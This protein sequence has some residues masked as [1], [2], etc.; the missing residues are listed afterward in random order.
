MAEP[1]RTVSPLPGNVSRWLR[2]ALGGLGRL[3]KRIAAVSGWRRFAVA[4]G[5][6]ALATAALPPVHLLVLLVPA[7]VGLV[8]LIDAS[9]RPRTAFAAGWWFGFGHFTAG[10]YW[11]AFALLTK[12]ERFGW[13]VPFAVFGLSALMALFP[14]CAALLTRAVRGDGPGR[15]LIF[16]A[17][18]TALEWVRGWAFTGFPWN[19]IGTAW[20][21]SDGMIQLAA[22]TGVYGLSLLSV[23]VAAMPAVL[24]DGG[25][26]AGRKAVPVAAA[27]IV[28][29]VVWGGGLVRLAGASDAVV[30]DVRLRL[31]QPNIDQKLK[32][33]PELRQQHVLRQVRMSTAAAGATQGD[34]APTHVIWAETAAPLVLGSDPASLGVIGGAAP[35]GGL[36]ITGTIRRTPPREKPFRI[37]N[38][39]QAVD[40]RAR[41][42]A[43]YDKF[44]LV[45]FG[46]YVPFRGLLNI[47]KVTEGQV[48]FARGPGVRTLRL[49]GLPPVSPLIC[50]EV[51]FPGRVADRQDRPSWLLNITNDAWYGRSSGPYQHF[52]AAR[53]RAVEEGLPLVRVAGTGISAVVDAYGRTVARLGLGRAG[54]IDSALPAPLAGATPYGR[55][56]DRIVLLILIA[57]AGAGYVLQRA[58]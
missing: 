20:V 25:A 35:P 53:M 51:I 26:W 11:I 17:A 3:Q 9:P 16:G 5:L 21:F 27:F 28:L 22:V 4:A 7:F 6:G 50:Y 39:L 32:W 29:G 10:L 23:V 30:P 45:P 13:M 47:A 44:H 48:D 24:T 54:V 36:I 12:P 31:V 49:P 38:S 57:V 37:W 19:L 1:G 2:P 34:G 46:E 8:W 33:R 18:W 58:R 52:A 41:V 15:I 56:G 42:V 14:A 55:L 43:T 40:D